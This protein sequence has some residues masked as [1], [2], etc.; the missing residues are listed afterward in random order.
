[1]SKPV[2][3]AIVQ[4]TR[5]MMLPQLPGMQVMHALVG[6]QKRWIN[7][8]MRRFH[9]LDMI[10]ALVTADANI[11]WNTTLATAPSLPLDVAFL[12]GCDVK[13]FPITSIAAV[14]PPQVSR[15]AWPAGRCRL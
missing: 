1:M 11:R 3:N 5:L 12:S 10:D 6:C 8:L 2:R 4:W 15:S 14:P 13:D 9:S 7:S